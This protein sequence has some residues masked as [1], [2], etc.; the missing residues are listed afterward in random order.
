[1]PSSGVSEDS[2]SILMCIKYMSLRRIVVDPPIGLMTPLAPWV[3]SLAPSLG[4]PVFH[5]IDDCEHSFL[6]LPGNGIAS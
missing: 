6:Y 2:D 4:G 1:M 3:R 5:P